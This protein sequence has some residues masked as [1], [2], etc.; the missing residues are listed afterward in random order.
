MF[1][2]SQLKPGYGEP[3]CVDLYELVT[4]SGAPGKGQA[5]YF[6]IATLIHWLHVSDACHLLI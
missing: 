2:V 1:H 6:H 4:V 5:K 3:F